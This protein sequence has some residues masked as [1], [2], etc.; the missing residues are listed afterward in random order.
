MLVFL[1]VVVV[2]A[3]SVLNEINILHLNFSFLLLL[4]VY[5]RKDTLE[6][7]MLAFYASLLASTLHSC[8]NVFL[9]ASIVYI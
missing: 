9:K 3:M 5:P 2:V 6:C 8:S 4:I 1:F 7:F